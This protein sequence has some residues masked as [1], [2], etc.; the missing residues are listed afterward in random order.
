MVLVEMAES[1]E[2]VWVEMELQCSPF[3][4]NPVP[5]CGARSWGVRGEFEI[6]LLGAKGRGKRTRERG[7]RKEWTLQGLALM[8]LGSGQPSSQPKVVSTSMEGCTGR[9]CGC[10]VLKKWRG[11]REGLI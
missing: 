11:N 7:M 4:W 9:L 3:G 2:E 8:S 10:K 6:G 5:I 1:N